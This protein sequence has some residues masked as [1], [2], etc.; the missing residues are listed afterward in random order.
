MTHRSRILAASTAIA[1]ASLGAPAWAEGTPAGQTITNTVTGT[2]EVAAIEQPALTSSISVLVDRK[3]NLLVSEVGGAPT[4][5]APG[6]SLSSAAFKV[7]NLSNAPIDMALTF[8][9]LTTGTDLVHG[10][11]KDGFDLNGVNLYLDQDEDGILDTA[12]DPK[13]TFLDDVPADREWVIFVAGAIPNGL[14]NGAA[15]GVRLTATAHEPAD[16][17]ALG[18]LL[19]ATQGG[20]SAQVD[21]VLADAAGA[22]DT[23][24]DGRFSALDGWIIYTAGLTLTK[25]F[26]LISH[27]LTGAY[28]T[29]LLP[30]TVIEFCVIAANGDGNAAAT[31]VRLADPLPPEFTFDMSFGIMVNGTATT[32]TCNDDGSRGGT[33]SAG[34]A[35]ATFDSIEGGSSTTMRYRATLN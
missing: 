22:G 8:E 1:L 31:Q 30:G 25:T 24:S 26:K 7:A 21:T 19:T 4:S 12:K 15:A 5:V 34:T 14:Q 11:A 3:I 13:V 6:V 29:P 18:A 20:D 23:A 27:P 10:Q 2:Y 35:Y 32:G 9:Q 33:F 16:P 17:E 28:G